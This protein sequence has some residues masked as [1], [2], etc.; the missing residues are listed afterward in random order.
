MTLVVNTAEQ[1][2]VAEQF[3]ALSR[4]WK[5]ETAF[6]SSTTAL[7][8]HPAYRAIIAL[9][10][11]TVPLLLRDLKNESAHW[12]EAL[13]TI[14]GDDPVAR[15]QWVNIPAMKAAWLSWGRERGLI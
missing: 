11:A 1:S 13:Q 5:A 14:T 7:V 4:Q 12:F 3:E 15:D 9:G 2:A 10:S 6:L 8:T